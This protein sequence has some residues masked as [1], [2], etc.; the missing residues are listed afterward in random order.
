MLAVARDKAAGLGLDADLRVGDAQSL[1][2]GDE[3]FDTVVCTLGLC[4]IP[5]ER[6]A[7]R[8]AWRVLR[9]GGRL[10]LLEH[11]RSPVRAVRVA[12]ELLEPLFLA[13]ARD[14]LLREPADAVDCAGFEI[15]GLQRSKRGIV[16]RLSA[17]KAAG[18]VR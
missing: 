10:L 15:D 9:P 11:V 4:S 8:E 2:F 14:H 13:V 7:V 16:E 1:P 5:D 17:R 6:G 3:S 18:T 12:Q